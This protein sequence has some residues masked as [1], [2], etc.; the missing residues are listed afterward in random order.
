MKFLK[1]NYQYENNSENSILQKRLLKILNII[2]LFQLIIPTMLMAV[3]STPYI[4][5]REIIEK[6]SF[7]EAGQKALE[8]RVTD[9]HAEVKSG[10]KALRSEM[11]SGQEAL[12]SEMKLG[13]ES[14]R[15]EM[16]LG[17]EALNIRINDINLTMLT[18]FGAIITL[19][20][21]LFAY[22]TWDRRSIIKP[23]IHQVNKLEQD[24]VNDLELR[25]V[26]GSLL[27]R[28]QKIFRSFARKNSD[29]ADSMGDATV[30]NH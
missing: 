12:R 7:L 28:H 27:Q 1:T 17:Y 25:H 16:K 26:N 6:L 5:D 24:V 13:Y 22:I 14:L 9:L 30:L 23:L 18:L 19:I 11:K 20:V 8:Q 4:S 29:F 15:S 3:E 10:Q 2:I 21:A